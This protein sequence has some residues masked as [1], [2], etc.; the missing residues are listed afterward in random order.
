MAS[1]LLHIRMSE[2]EYFEMLEKSLHKYEYWHGVA[3]A[4]VGAQP[5]HVRVETNIVGEL[6]QKLRG[7]DCLPLVSNQAV[8]LAKETGYVFPD[9]TVV[10]GEPQY[11]IKGGIGC[12]LNPTAVFEVLSPST[13]NTDENDKLTAYAAIRTIREYV[14]V[15]S[16]RRC[17]KHFSR[18]TA[19]ELWRV[20]PCEL[21]TDSIDLES[22]GCSLTLAEI[23]AGLNLRKATDSLANL[24]S[25]F[26]EPANALNRRRT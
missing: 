5:P 21:L 13:A 1:P 24:D 4:M 7:K 2:D 9:V 15:S 3:V 20:R 18:R 14:I 12:L 22:C 6:F 23:Y 17:V 19:D 25:P 11:V 16:D 26:D 8:K 10:C